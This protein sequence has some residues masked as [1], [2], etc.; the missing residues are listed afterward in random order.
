MILIVG[1]NSFLAK[2]FSNAQNG[3]R[4]I[5][6]QDIYRT[7]VY[8]D[9]KTVINF[10]F[11]DNFYM[12]KYNE[13]EDI[14]SAIAQIIENKR[15]NFIQISSRKVYGKY[16]GSPFKEE[17]VCSPYDYYGE[18]KLIIEKKL[19]NILKPNLYILRPG[20]IVGNEID[21][22]RQSFCGYI[23]KQLVENNGEINLTVSPKS[24]KNI[25]PVDCF[26]SALIMLSSG[27]ASP[28]I[29]NI[30]SSSSITVQDFV[31]SII[32]GFGSGCI[33]DESN[34]MADNFDINVN[35][36]SR[37]IYFDNSILALLNYCYKLGSLI[38][39]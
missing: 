22:T 39:N 3:L 35:K 8:R 1:A 17:D 19:T 28:G 9:I 33:H 36:I 2:N 12:S 25:L 7:E 16:L 26:L 32:E 29:Y 15:I 5:S 27:S 14:D 38:K 6:H 31:N 24:I 37:E 18:N 10:S 21:R 30:G 20:N 11:S 34:G 4:I 23:T 13:K